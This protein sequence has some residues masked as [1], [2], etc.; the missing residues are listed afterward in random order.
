MAILRPRW[1]AKAKLVHKQWKPQHKLCQAFQHSPWEKFSKYLDQIWLCEVSVGW[2]YSKQLVLSLL[3]NLFLLTSWKNY[4]LHPKM[5]QQ[6]MFAFYGQWRNLV[7]TGRPEMG[8]IGEK[9]SK[10]CSLMDNLPE[11]L[12]WLQI[13]D[14]KTPLRNFSCPRIIMPFGWPPLVTTT[15][16]WTWTRAGNTTYVYTSRPRELVSLDCGGGSWP[17]WLSLMAL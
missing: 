5:E 7:K 17:I 12:Y 6:W 14:S 10:N 16:P 3:S 11:E 13:S 2:K 9:K 1:R 8:H 4:P 15:M